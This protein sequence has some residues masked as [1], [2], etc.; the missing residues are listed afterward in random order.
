MRFYSPYS[1]GGEACI[2]PSRLITEE[3]SVNFC[4]IGSFLSV[5][6][7]FEHTCLPGANI[8]HR[9]YP[10]RNFVSSLNK[11]QPLEFVRLYGL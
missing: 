1:R 6:R 10:R 5:T 3:V 2:G 9:P 4:R 8:M 7:S 11:R